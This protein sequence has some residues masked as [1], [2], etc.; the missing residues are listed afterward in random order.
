[1]ENTVVKYSTLIMIIVLLS[2]L[3]NSCKKDEENQ[4]S[5]EQDNIGNLVVNNETNKTLLLY[6]ESKLI[7]EIPPS[8]NSFV[9]SINS[10]GFSTSLKVWE[11]VKVQDKNNPS[12]SEKFRQWDVVLPSINIDANSRALWIIKDDG[13]STTASGTLKFTYP[14]IDTTNNIQVIYSV[15]VVLDNQEGSKITSLAPGTVDKQVG[16]EYG[17]RVLLFQYWYSDQNSATGRVDV[18]WKMSDSKGENFSAILNANY[19]SARIDIP[20]YYFSPIGRTSEVIFDNNTNKDIQV[21]ANDNLI[22]DI[23]I[24]D[25]PKQGLSLIRR[26]SQNVKYI[27]PEGQY[28]FDINTISSAENLENKTIQLIELYPYIWRLN[29]ENDYHSMYVEN[30]TEKRI[31]FH[32]NSNGE[33]LGFWLDIDESGSFEVENSINS[34]LA[35]GWLN[36]SKTS[37]TTNT[38]NWIIND[39]N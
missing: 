24:S 5:N 34:I 38:T 23:V 6:N 35:K 3:F 27:I 11:K 30:K 21:Y 33:Y 31:T 18:D 29:G 22:E 16:V 8:D 20:I 2:I 1:M 26:D 25:K 9:I 12:E 19:S 36:S 39:L 28:T 14:E 15:D 13:S 7:K 17:Y 37:S 10:T 4:I 32:N